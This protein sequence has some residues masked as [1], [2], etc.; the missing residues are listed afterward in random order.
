MSALEKKGIFLGIIT[1]KRSFSGASSQRFL[2]KGVFFSPGKISDRV[3]FLIWRTIIRPPFYM[4]VA[5]PGADY[6]IIL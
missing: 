3:I 1:E 4:R 2:I 5:G 6:R